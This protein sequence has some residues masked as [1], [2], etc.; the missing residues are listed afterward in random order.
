MEEKEILEQQQTNEPESSDGSGYQEYINTINDLKANS[1]SK[2]KY[3]QLVKEKNGLIEAL[4]TGGQ[5]N[6]QSE[7][8]KVDIDQL[9]NELYGVNKKDMTNLEYFE[10]TLKLR[11]ALLDQGEKDP[12]LPNGEGYTETAEDIEKANYYASV[13]QE[14]IDYA[15]GNSQLFTQELQRRTKDDTPLRGLNNIRRN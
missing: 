14:C 9:R 8:E 11:K 13:Y 1:V 6:I 12:F 15:Q 4:K 7:E 5:V 2:E 3:D 10:K